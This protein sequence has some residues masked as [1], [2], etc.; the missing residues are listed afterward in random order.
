MPGK[1]VR[2]NASRLPNDPSVDELPPLETVP[3]P[4]VRE[5]VERRWFGLPARF[6]LLCLG[7]AGMGAAVGLFAT[8]SWAWGFVAVLLAVIFFAALSEAVRQGGSLIP[9]QSGRLAADGRAQAAT[10]AEVLR[11]RAE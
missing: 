2:M 9:E 1:R 7:C 3:G 8:G 5:R 10:A 4:V 6:V 11:T